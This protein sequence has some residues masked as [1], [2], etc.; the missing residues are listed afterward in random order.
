MRPAPAVTVTCSGGSGWRAVRA[1]LPALAAAALT[2][3]VLLHLELPVWPAGFTGLVTAM[4]A[5]RLARP[6]AQTLRWDGQAWT[7]DGTP[8]GLALMIDVGPA[9]LLRLRPGAGA[10]RWIAVTQ[11][12]AGSAWH[13]LRAALYSRPSKTNAPR[14]LPT[15]RAD[16]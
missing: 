16:Y 6:R 11:G 2:A 9:L 1:V 13:S 14:V 15:E 5:W 12:E 10:A 7:D 3:F 4:A 8:G